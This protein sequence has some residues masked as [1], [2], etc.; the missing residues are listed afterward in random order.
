MEGALLLKVEA[1]AAR[2]GVGRST[3]YETIRRGEIESVLIGRS[4]RIPAAAVEAYVA[5]LRGEGVGQ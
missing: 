5:R 2:L 4:R 3:L 1:A